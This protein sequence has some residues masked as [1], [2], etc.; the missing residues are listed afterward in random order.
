M[1]VTLAVVLSVLAILGNVVGFILPTDGQ[2]VPPII[3]IG[4][5]SL[6]VA[7]IP[8]AVALW[9]LR[10]WGLIPALAVTALS[11]LLTVPEI[12]LA[13]MMAIQIFPVVFA[14]LYAAIL[15]LVLRPDTRRAYRRAQSAGRHPSTSLHVTGTPPVD[16]HRFYVSFSPPVRTDAASFKTSR[17]VSVSRFGT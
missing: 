14:L 3:A 15:V 9:L 10:Q 11:L 6:A 13:P 2:E 8:V 4:S 1:T 16:T 5:V 12:A 17:R 7:G